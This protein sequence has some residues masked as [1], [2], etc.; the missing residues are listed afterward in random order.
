MV[1]LLDLIRKRMEGPEIISEMKLFHAKWKFSI[2]GVETIAFQKMIAQYAKREGLPIREI[3]QKNDS[4]YKIDKDKTAR[5]LSATPLMADRR[6]FVPFYAPWLADYINELILFPNAAHDD[7]VDVTA[8]GVAIAQ[9][10]R[11]WHN[12]SE[13]HPRERA[14]PRNHED[15]VQSDNPYDRL[16]IQP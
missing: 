15:G 10:I 14:L 3:G 9:T 16:A 5:A 6:F 11:A 12:N 2:M 7:Q 8:Y 1:F 13:S 4:I